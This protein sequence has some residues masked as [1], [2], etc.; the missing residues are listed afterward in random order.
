MI[1]TNSEQ[2][3]ITSYLST[4]SDTSVAIL[5]HLKQRTVN[6]H[7]AVS[8]YKIKLEKNLQD[9]CL[10]KPYNC[11]ISVGLIMERMLEHYIK[12]VHF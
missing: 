5:R 11:I 8:T 2:F 9:I 1:T 4:A 12:T 7:T 6:I 10:S 3:F